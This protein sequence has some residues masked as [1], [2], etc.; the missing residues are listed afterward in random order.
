MMIIII[1]IIIIIIIITRIS[2]KDDGY[3]RACEKK[4]KAENLWDFRFVSCRYKGM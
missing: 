3:E 4:E 2:N 1:T